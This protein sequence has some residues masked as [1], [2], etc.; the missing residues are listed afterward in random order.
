MHV[1]IS[2]FPPVPS[3]TTPPLEQH[4]DLHEMLLRIALEAGIEI[5]YDA[6][7]SHVTPGDELLEDDLPH[8][9]VNGSG[10]VCTPSPGCSCSI[11]ATS[12]SVTGHGPPSVQLT[13]GEMLIADII[14][15]ADGSRSM[16]R[17]LLLEPEQ[18]H[19]VESGYNV[20]S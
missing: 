5:R 14:V 7:V 20:Y 11:S 15:G 10:I 18:D 8:Q 13:N 12:A 2:L 9:S 4:K 1:S 3:L 6:R 19:G 16:V 17:E